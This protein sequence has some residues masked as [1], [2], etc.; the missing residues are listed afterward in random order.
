MGLLNPT[1]GKIT[2]DN[3]IINNDNIKAWRRK[4]S[5]V[6]QKIFLVKDTIKKNIAFSERSDVINQQLTDLAVKVSGLN[7]IESLPNKI[8]SDIGE[9]GSLLSGGQRQ[10]VGIARSIY[11]NTEILTFDEATSA[12]D[13]NL[14]QEIFDNLDKYLNDKTFIAITHDSNQLSFFDKIIHLKENFEYEIK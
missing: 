1:K 9:D 12:I 2:C 6:P 7:F 14:R 3:T 11:D 8:D 4:F 10:R 5:H 13:S